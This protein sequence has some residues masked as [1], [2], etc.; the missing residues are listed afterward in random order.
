MG[1][2]AI[3]RRWLSGE[4]EW[5]QDLSERFSVLIVDKKAAHITYVTDLM[6]F[7]PVYRFKGKTPP[8][9]ELT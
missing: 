9:W 5:D 8:F 6:M 4:I 1:T 2:E 7:I 3:Y